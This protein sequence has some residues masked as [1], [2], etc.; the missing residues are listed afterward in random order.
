MSSRLQP[1]HNKVFMRTIEEKGHE[2]TSRPMTSSLY[3]MNRFESPGNSSIFKIGP[4]KES[5]SRVHNSRQRVRYGS[6]RSFVDVCDTRWSWWRRVAREI[7]PG[8]VVGSSRWEL[9]GNRDCT[10]NMQNSLSLKTG[11][12][13][14][15]R[16]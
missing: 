8:M 12:S 6:L 10:C 9:G 3:V 16:F 11:A 1:H 5:H 15:P 2:T 14:L 7:Y 4:I 13:L